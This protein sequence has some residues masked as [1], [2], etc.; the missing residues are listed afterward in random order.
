AT[1]ATPSHTPGDE[2][3]RTAERRAG[4]FVGL[5]GRPGF[6]IVS[7]IIRLDDPYRRQL[8]PGGWMRALTTVG[9]ALLTGAAGLEAQHARE[10]EFSMFGS[11]TKYDASFNL[12]KKIGGGVHQGYEFG[13]HEGLE[14]CELYTTAFILWPSTSP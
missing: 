5:G 13:D 11:Y 7:E 2:R 14:T 3:H 8:P 9:L 10:Y 1:T 12:A 6:L 4:S